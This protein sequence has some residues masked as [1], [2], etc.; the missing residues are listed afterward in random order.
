MR[1]ILHKKK[2]PKHG[3][4]R[5]VKRFLLFPAIAPNTNGE[6]E[7][8]WLERAT[9]FQQFNDISM[10]CLQVGVDDG[11]MWKNIRWEQT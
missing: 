1:K 6:R 2:H 11:S 3:D 9:I 8:R 5:T 4:R 7:I 10:W